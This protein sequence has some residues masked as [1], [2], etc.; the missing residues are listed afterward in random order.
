MGAKYNSNPSGGG[1]FWFRPANG[2]YLLELT[3]SEAAQVKVY[4]SEET[5]PGYIL[6]F[7]IGSFP[8]F[9]P[10][11]NEAGDDRVFHFEVADSLHPK[12]NAYKVLQPL[13]ARDLVDG[14]D[15]D[16]LITEG[17][18]KQII[19]NFAKSEKGKDGTL[20]AAMPF[21]AVN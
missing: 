8:D 16:D 3:G 20:V 9:T 14:D 6:S 1:D 19:A 11:K 10:L 21:K 13:V 5:K 18:G 4:E 12:S 17:T 15:I 7:G 2:M